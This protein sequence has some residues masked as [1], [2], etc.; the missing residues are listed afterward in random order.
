M[1][2]VII[3]VPAAVF[4]PDVVNLMTLPPATTFSAVG[5][6]VLAV[7]SVSVVATVI[8]PFVMAVDPMAPVKTAEPTVGVASHTAVAETMVP[9]P[10][11]GTATYP[12]RAVAEM[13]VSGGSQPLEKISAN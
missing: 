7:P 8:A 4:P 3:A 6:T 12:T 2:R 10:P 1:V 9:A 11:S 5:T 13:I